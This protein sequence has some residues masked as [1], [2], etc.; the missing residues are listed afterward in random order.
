[1]GQA[2]YLLRQPAHVGGRRFSGWRIKG[3]SG[4]LTGSEAVRCL[5]GSFLQLRIQQITRL[6]E[7]EAGRFVIH[8]TMKRVG[9][10]E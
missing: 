9:F 10:I 8:L 5:V 7:R 1:M 2:V 4:S 6:R 3:G